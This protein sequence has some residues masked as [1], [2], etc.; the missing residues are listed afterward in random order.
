M[1]KLVPCARLLRT[2]CA[3]LFLTASA[4]RIGAGHGPA[5]PWP[6]L[7]N[8]GGG[9]GTHAADGGG[10]S[11]AGASAGSSGAFSP[12]D[13]AG[14]G[15][16]SD[17]AIQLSGDASVNPA[18]CKAP[19]T[20]AVC[21]PVQNTGCGTGSQCDVDLVQPVLSG[22]CAFTSPMDAGACF[23]SP[24]TESCP[25][26]TTCD[27]G[28]CRTLCFCDTDCPQGECCHDTLGT[29]GFKLCQPCH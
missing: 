25:A 1:K 17:A 2:A 5:D 8:G 29:L 12:G 13:D 28:T 22:R 14:T 7:S 23:T 24:F 18:P 26:K 4:C 20:V 16:A 9:A 21:D 15:L 27:N 6:K 19:S 10:K 11:G 3:L